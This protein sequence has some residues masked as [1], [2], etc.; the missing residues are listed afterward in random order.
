MEMNYFNITDTISWLFRLILNLYA[1]GRSDI[2]CGPLK[3]QNEGISTFSAG[4]LGLG[5]VGPCH[6]SGCH[7]RGHWG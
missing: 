1:F 5:G 3:I 7:E 4:V 2:F 6:G